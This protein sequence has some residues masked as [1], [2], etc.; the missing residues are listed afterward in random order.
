[1]SSLRVRDLQYP[2]AAGRIHRAQEHRRR[3]PAG[4]ASRR[5]F[6][7]VSS[8]PMSIETT[9]V[10]WL[11][12]D[13]LPGNG[14]QVR[15][16]GVVSGNASGDVTAAAGNGSS[17]PGAAAAA[18]AAKPQ[19]MVDTLLVSIV[20]VGLVGNTLA[21]SALSSRGCRGRRRRWRTHHALAI[22]LQVGDL[23]DLV[24]N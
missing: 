4:N 3:S 14:S 9:P 16:D 13:R 20:C 1:M 7:Q 23:L 10:Y 17:D 5:L 15:G 22:L 21:F 19:R 2:F 11:T 6:M 18:A 24:T 12:G 8:L